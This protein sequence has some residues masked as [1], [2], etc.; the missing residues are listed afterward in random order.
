MG[1]TAYYDA[2][3]TLANNILEDA[4]CYMA[5]KSHVQ[6]V[7]H[8]LESDPI[9]EPKE[10]VPIGLDYVDEGQTEKITEAVTTA[11]CAISNADRRG[12]EILQTL[13][14]SSKSLKNAQVYQDTLALYRK[15]FEACSRVRDMD[16]LSFQADWF[17]DIYRRNYD[18]LM[19]KSVHD[20]VIEDVDKVRYWLHCLRRGARF[21]APHREDRKLVGN[22]DLKPS[23]LF[24]TLVS[25]LKFNKDEREEDDPGGVPVR[26][27]LKWSPAPPLLLTGWLGFPLLVLLVLVTS[28]WACTAASHVVL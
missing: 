27:S 4:E 11:R 14:S 15:A 13:T 18:A 1:T 5:L 26:S 16:K 10:K 28:F 24:E 8:N 7:P 20:N 21:G 3:F 2:I 22:D 19:I 12:R 23:R 9:P 25:P 17:K 6:R